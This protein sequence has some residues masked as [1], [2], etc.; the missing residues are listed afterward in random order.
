MKY[1]KHDYKQLIST[2]NGRSNYIRDTRYKSVLLV[3]TGLLWRKAIPSKWVSK[4]H[5]DALNPS[6]I[7]P[8][9]RKLFLKHTGNHICLN[10]HVCSYDAECI[11]VGLLRNE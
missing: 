11:N 10:K 1:K 4:V 7:R 8:S 3:E 6:F 2:F 9:T 5:T